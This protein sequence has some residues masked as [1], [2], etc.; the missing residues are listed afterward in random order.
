MK[1]TK[2]AMFM[3][4]LSLV[5]SCGREDVEPPELDYQLKIL[6]F[7][8]ADARFAPYTL[9][10][11]TR[12]IESWSDLVDDAQYNGALLYD[13]TGGVYRWADA[14]GTELSHSF[15]T[16]YWAGGHAISNYVIADYKNLPEGYFGWYEL[17]LAT[18]AGGH[19]GSKNFAV[20]N[21]S[22]MATDDLQL[23]ALVFADGAARV[24]DHMYV[25]NTCY[26]LSALIYGDSFSAP[27]SDESLLKLVATGYDAAGESAGSV[28]LVLCRGK[29]PLKEWTRFELHTLGAVS[30]VEFSFWASDDLI[31]DYGIRVPTYFAYDDVA[32]RFENE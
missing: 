22:Q 28:E 1:R 16:P 13:Q 31:G 17:Q 5:A 29:E 15:T 11:C 18:P 21:G 9:S 32:V 4:L 2:L 7:E 6:T 14:G 25:T 23:P 3:A 24:I 10:Y 26:V 30:R 27:A 19:N 20:H 8:D 12:E